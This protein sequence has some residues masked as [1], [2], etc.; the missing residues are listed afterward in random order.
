[1]I[2]DDCITRVLH[3]LHEL[4]GSLFLDLGTLAESFEVDIVVG[5]ELK[6]E[7]R[8]KDIHFIFSLGTAYT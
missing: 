4:H 7:P 5:G 8:Y 3:L 2:V 6:S 1:M